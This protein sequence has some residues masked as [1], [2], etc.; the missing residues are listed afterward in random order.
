MSKLSLELNVGISSFIWPLICILVYKHHIFT[1]TSDMYF[2]TRHNLDGVN[3]VD[4]QRSLSTV[5]PVTG[6]FF[7]ILFKKIL[8]AISPFIP[9]LIHL[10]TGN[11]VKMK[12]IRHSLTWYILIEQLLC[13]QHHSWWYADAAFALIRS[14]FGKVSCIEVTYFHRFKEESF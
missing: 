6:S 5:P 1:P 4:K 7:T 2:H 12:L 10:L 9:S 3:L 14:H 13:A 11:M 8:Y